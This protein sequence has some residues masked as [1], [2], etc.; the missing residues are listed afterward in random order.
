M[1]KTGDT[2]FLAQRSGMTLGRFFALHLQGA[3]FLVA[4]AIMLYGW[5]GAVVLAGVT[6]FT[7]LGMLLWKRVGV[8]GAQLK[9]SHGVWLGLLLGLMLPAHLAGAAQPAAQREILW[10]LIPAAGLLLSGLI[11]LLGG[12][13]VSRIHPLLMAYLLLVVLFRVELVPHYVLQRNHMVTGDIFKTSVDRPFPFRQPWMSGPIMPGQ[14]ALYWR[15][16]ASEQ[17]LAL[18]SFSQSPDQPTLTLAEVLRDK[19]P[20]L[21]DLIVAGHPGPLGTGSAIA[22]I[23]GG[24]FLLYRGLIDYRIPLLIVIF[25]YLALLVLPIPTSITDDVRNWHW[26]AWRQGGVGWPIALTLVNYEIMAGPTLFMAFFLAGAG[27]IRPMTGRGRII[28]AVLVGIV[29]AACLLYFSVS[30]GP[31]LALLLVSLLTPLLDW[32]LKPRALV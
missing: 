27:G 24:L 31:Y 26:T 11:W 14:D 3:V 29:T 22:V 16:P 2:S 28:Y 5:R 23:I 6:G 17:L 25:C 8:R 15:Q 19:M 18:T 4:V 7:L 32:L 21:E 13:G 9:L 20:P 12:A 1:T 10:P 30:F